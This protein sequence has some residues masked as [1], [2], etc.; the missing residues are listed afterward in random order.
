MKSRIKAPKIKM[1][2]EYDIIVK[3][4]VSGKETQRFKAYNTVLT[5]QVAE[6]L[7]RI[8][9]FTQRYS[10]DM[11][12]EGI[13]YI[14]FGSGTGTPTASDT[15]LSNQI[16]RL[17]AT[18]ESYSITRALSTATYKM[19]IGETSY[20]GETITE[21]GLT[22]EWYN[23]YYLIS[24]ALLKD[25]E[26]NP[27]SIG[28]KTDVQIIEI[29]AT[30]YIE[31]P[32]NIGSGWKWF[33]TNRYNKGLILGGGSYG[34]YMPD[35]ICA[36]VYPDR[37]EKLITTTSVGDVDT[38]TL[39]RLLSTQANGDGSQDIIAVALQEFG[40]IP[41]PNTTYFP[42]MSFAE[43]S[44]G[45]GDGTK[46]GFKLTTDYYKPGTEVI[47]VD[48]VAQTRNTDY[49][50][51]QGG[52]KNIGFNEVPIPYK[53]DTVVY[54]NTIGGDTDLIL[55]NGALR[56]TDIRDPWIIDI[57][58]VRDDLD[59][60]SFYANTNLNGF[61]Y[62]YSA[63]GINWTTVAND[64]WLLDDAWRNYTL[65]GIPARYFFIQS[66]YTASSY[67]L[68]YVRIFI[69]DSIQFTTAPAAPAAITASWDTDVPPKTSDYSYDFELEIDWS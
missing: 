55:C 20:V 22:A 56:D 57:G 36:N 43:Q 14:N 61:Y 6:Y 68:D 26:G 41:F 37:I 52:K 59:Y 5:A 50:I 34:L 17:S 65:K 46:T 51:K 60:I 1:H 11:H 13:K 16:A 54:R 25:S 47:K 64:I 62:K 3:D 29:Y 28:P 7:S 19:T 38:L 35:D 21:L 27:I 31:L 8:R 48:G 66:L 2:N 69:D 15:T 53:P 18:R 63:D 67:G 24:H 30:V 33:K 40:Y 42:T 39:D 12:P 32:E 23:E 49:T 10:N 4:S 44:I 58:E 45:T 9:L